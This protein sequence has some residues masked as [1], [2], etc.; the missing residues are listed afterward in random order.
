MAAA[1]SEGSLQIP[2]STSSLLSVSL[3]LPL[4]SPLFSPS[5][6][7]SHSVLSS[8]C[9]LYIYL[10][11][12]RLLHST[13]IGTSV[14]LPSLVILSRAVFSLT[15]TPSICVDFKDPDAVV[16]L[17]ICTVYLWINNIC[18]RRGKTMGLSHFQQICQRFIISTNLL[19]EG[20]TRT[21][22]WYFPQP[23]TA[24]FY[25]GRKVS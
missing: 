20:D 6:F 21:C 8:L 22:Y 19:M 14:S 11:T 9:L 1:C 10:F 24:V 18:V 5:V 2:L 23:Y 16:K 13:Y 4:C 7:H 12:A 3:L 25:P 15:P 17:L